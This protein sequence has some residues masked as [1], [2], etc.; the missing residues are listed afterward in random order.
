MRAHRGGTGEGDLG[1]AL[2]GGQGFAGFAAKALDDVQH[3]C[4][5]QVGDQLGENGDRQWRLF[6]RLEHHAIAG[7]QGRGE[8][9][10]GHQQREVPRD[11][12]PDHAQRFMEMVGRG[13]FV[14]LCRAPFLGADAA[15]EITKVVCCQ[16]HVGI[17]GFAYGLAVVPAFGHSEHFQVLLDAVGDLQQHPRALLHRGLAPGFGG[18]VRGVQGQVDVLGSGAWEFGNRLA[19]DRRAVGEVLATQRWHKRAADE[20]AIA[21]FEGHDS[22]WRSGLCVDHAEPLRVDACPT[23]GDGAMV[24]S[25]ACQTNAS[26]AVEVSSFGSR[27]GKGRGSV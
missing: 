19:I 16:R 13:Q 4:R 22:A 5:Q 17:E 26:L 14:D 6:R 12:L 15:G 23:T 24:K 8:F 18:G 10:G 20:I 25:P 11:D 7:G 3:A 2:A 21:G 27:G 1:D 9:P